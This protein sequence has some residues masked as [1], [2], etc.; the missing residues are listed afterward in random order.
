MAILTG[1]YNL[2]F[3]GFTLIIIVLAQQQHAS[4]F[5]IGLIFAVGGIG[6]ILGGFIATSLQK[7]LNFS[8]ALICTALIFS[9]FLAFY[10]LATN[11]LLLGIFTAANFFS[12]AV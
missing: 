10:C 7:R 9:L 1:G 3:A 11:P 12:R 8:Q 5:T 2:I 4:S 6:G